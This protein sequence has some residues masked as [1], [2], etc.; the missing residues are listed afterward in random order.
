[1]RAIADESVFIT[2]HVSIR[3]SRRIRPGQYAPPP[4][5]IQSRSRRNA[6]GLHVVH[7]SATAT[8]NS[9]LLIP[10]PSSSEL[11]SCNISDMELHELPDVIAGGNDDDGDDDTETTRHKLCRYGTCSSI[12][13]AF[14]MSE[15]A[16]RSIAGDP[17]NATMY[18]RLFDGPS[19]SGQELRQLVMKKWG[20]S[21]DIRLHKRG[22]R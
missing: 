12:A 22:T 15:T 18:T 16:L 9:Q 10:T 5:L 14:M 11:L 13:D 3:R 4:H 6:A 7:A 2:G 19:I 1:M 21:Y 20:R 17:L 8:G